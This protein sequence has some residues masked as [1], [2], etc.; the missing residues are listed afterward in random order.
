MNRSLCLL[1][2]TTLFCFLAAA[3]D[4]TH[5][6]SVPGHTSQQSAFL[7]WAATHSKSYSTVEEMEF[8]F[9]Q[10]VKKDAELEEIQ[11]SHPYATFTV[12][13]NIFS[14]R[15]AEEMAQKLSKNY[16]TPF[17]SEGVADQPRA[18]SQDVQPRDRVRSGFGDK[19]W[20]DSY[21]NEIQD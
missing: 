20:C 3:F 15:T 4:A 10:F 6:A 7:R 9:Q 13:H 21:C 12:A 11:V 14:D 19:N 17:I 5:T 16:M 2:S 8:R 18:D 1:L